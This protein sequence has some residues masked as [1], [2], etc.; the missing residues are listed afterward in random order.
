MTRPSLTVDAGARLIAS[1]LL[2]EA[3]AAAGRLAE[4]ASEEALHDFRVAVRRLRT[5]LRAFKRELSPAVTRRTRRALRSIVRTTNLGR[6]SAVQLEWLRDRRHRF[7]IAEREGV[8]W[9]AA[10]LERKRAGSA[11]T[12]SRSPAGVS[13]T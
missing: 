7:T 5:W 9:L 3:G 4:D 8:D 1:E 11:R 12:S 6:D 10:Q 13:A 2:V